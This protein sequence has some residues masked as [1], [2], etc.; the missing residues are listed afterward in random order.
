MRGACW[1]YSLLDAGGRDAFFPPR[2]VLRSQT[3][4]VTYRHHRRGRGPFETWLGSELARQALEHGAPEL[5][6]IRL[7]PYLETS[8]R[9]V[10]WIEFRRSRRGDPPREGWGF[11]VELSKP[12][13]RPVALGYG[14]HFGLGQLR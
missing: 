1:K 14:A 11:E 8:K 9:P 13:C 2:Q 5:A 6:A 12:S 10:R 3:P 7:L 4:F